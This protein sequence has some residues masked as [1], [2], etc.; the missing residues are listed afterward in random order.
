MT[1]STLKQFMSEATRNALG[2]K[3]TWHYNCILATAKI[4]KNGQV[5]RGTGVARPGKT[6]RDKAKGEQPV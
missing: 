4:D 2:T 3:P 6:A 5:V 1:T